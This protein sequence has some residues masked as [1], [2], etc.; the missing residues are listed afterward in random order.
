MYDTRNSW[1]ILYDFFGKL[2]WTSP[3]TYL[4]I[5]GALGAPS[6]FIQGWRWVRAFWN[7][8]LLQFRYRS[9]FT[10]FYF[11]ARD[12]GYRIME[13][14]KTY[15][16]VR[17]EKVISKTKRLESIPI[18]YRWSGDGE[19][20]IHIEPA[21]LTLVDR[22]RLAG[23]VDARKSVVFEK[24]LSKRE[25][26]SFIVRMT[27]TATRRQPEPFVSSVSKRRVDSLILRVAFPVDKRPARVTYRLLDGDGLEKSHRTLE[28][29]D[30]LTGE[31]RAEI[32]YPKPFYDHRIEWE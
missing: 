4:S 15:L 19:I 27:C 29:S 16:N 17:R 5:L 14:G 23:T 31:Y 3:F 20:E 25:R 18:N 22:P 8:T 1:Q 7:T 9:V 13:D 6:A 24:P 11:E 32:R 26:C 21:S 10:D 30:Y 28:C 2:D 12:F